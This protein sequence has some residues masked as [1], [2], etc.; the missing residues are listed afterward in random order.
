MEKTLNSDEQRELTKRYRERTPVQLC[1]GSMVLDTLTEINVVDNTNIAD[2]V[3]I[4]AYTYIYQRLAD[5]A[6]P[7]QIDK[8]LART[9]EELS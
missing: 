7:N 2:Q 8:A 5:P 3:R 4:A 1:L 9:T 6:F